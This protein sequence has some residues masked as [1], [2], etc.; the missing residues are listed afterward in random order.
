[1][2]RASRAGETQGHPRLTRRSRTSRSTS[3]TTRTRPPSTMDQTKVHQ[4][5]LRARAVLVRQRMGLL[6]SHGRHRGRDGQADLTAARHPFSRASGR[7]WPC[8]ARA[9]EGR[10]GLPRFPTIAARGT[11]ISRPRRRYGDPHERLQHPRRRR[12]GPASGCWCA[13]IS[14]CRSRAVKRQRHDPHRARHPDHPPASRTGAARSC[15]WP[16]SGARKVARTKPIRSV[17]V[18]TYLMGDHLRPARELPAPHDR[19]EQAEQAVIATMQNGRR[20]AAREHP[21]PQ[22]RGKQR[23]RLRGGVGRARRSSM[24]MTPFPRLIEPMPR[25]RASPVKPPGLCGPHGMQAE[26]RGAVQARSRSVRTAR[27]P[28]SWAARKCRPSS[29]CSAIS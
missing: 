6:E 10:R 22:G 27:S 15:C 7:R 29:S 25:P 2:K 24:S 21:L 23:P 13:S 3:T 9:D 28:P 18:S 12:P 11:S 26:T 20:A 14:T 17:S 19:L 1:M 16:I 5:H 8:A 4:R